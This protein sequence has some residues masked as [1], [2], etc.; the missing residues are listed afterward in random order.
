MRPT[1][2]LL[3]LLTLPV[4]ADSDCLLNQYQRYTN[5]RIQWQQGVTDLIV[6][7]APAYRDVAEQY[8]DDQLQLIE[9]SQLAV[10]FLLREDPALLQT[11]EPLNQWL[12]LDAA[13]RERI[14]QQ[15]ER[16]A[17]LEALRMQRRDGPRHPNG[18]DL[19]SLMRST[20]MPS[21]R[22]QQ[23]TEQLATATAQANQR[24]CS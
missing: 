12:Q 18:N 11:D 13:Q 7:Q 16:F 4:L 6:E 5:A 20:V 19:R 17:E 8:R 23:L 14:A 22:Y 9:A 15:N 24:R 10:K 1:L 21:T 3:L 2:A